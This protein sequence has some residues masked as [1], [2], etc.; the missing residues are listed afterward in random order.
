MITVHFRAAYKKK[1]TTAFVHQQGCSP[2]V[3]VVCVE[4]EVGAV[5]RSGFHC[6]RCPHIQKNT[7]KILKPSTPKCNSKKH[8]KCAKHLCN[9]TTLMRRKAI[10]EKLAFGLRKVNWVCREKLVTQLDSLRMWVNEMRHTNSPASW[11]VAEILL[12]AQN[13]RTYIKN[14]N[15][16]DVG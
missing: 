2:R 13:L 9:G 7:D 11:Q 6:G 10:A 15:K 3:K 4:S 5:C 8:S 12:Y 1:P 14:D 16:Y